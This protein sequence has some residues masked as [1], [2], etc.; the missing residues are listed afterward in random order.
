LRGMS[1]QWSLENIAYRGLKIAGNTDL[2]F[3]Y[4]N[5][6]SAFVVGKFLSMAAFTSLTMNRAVAMKFADRLLYEIQEVMGADISHLSRY[7]EEKELLLIPPCVFLILA[8]RMEKDWLIV[9]LQHFRQ[10]GA[11]Y[12]SVD[13]TNA[14]DA[15][16]DDTNHGSSGNS[17]NSGNNGNSSSGDNNGN[18]SGNSSGNCS[19]NSSG[20]Y[21]GNNRDSGNSS[22]NN[23]NSASHQEG[24]CVNEAELNNYQNQNYF[25]PCE[26]SAG[27]NQTNQ[28]SPGGNDIEY[29]ADDTTEN[30]DEN[31]FYLLDD[32]SEFI[33]ASEKQKVTEF[34][35]V[36][37]IQSK[38]QIANLLH[39]DVE[40]F[41]L[42]Q[43]DATESEIGPTKFQD[44]LK[45]LYL[46][47]KM[48]SSSHVWIV[49]DKNSVNI[50]AT[51]VS[52][53]Q[54]CSRILSSVNVYPSETYHD[55][56]VT[57]AAQC[58]VELFEGRDLFMKAFSS[59][60]G[61]LVST[62]IFNEI[63]IRPLRQL[64]D[65]VYPRSPCTR[66]IVLKISSSSTDDGLIDFLV[67][68]SCFL[69]GWVKLVVV[70]EVV[71]SCAV[72]ASSRFL[73]IDDVG[74]K[75]QQPGAKPE[76]VN[77]PM[78]AEIPLAPQS[79]ADIVRSFYE[80]EGKWTG[81][82][83]S[84]GTYP[85]KSFPQITM[86]PDFGI[87]MSGGGLRA[88]A[89][90][91]GWL[92]ALNKHGLITKARYISVNSGGSWITEPLLWSAVLNGN[93]KVNSSMTVAEVDAVYSAEI[94]ASA[95]YQVPRALTQDFGGEVLDQMGHNFWR[96]HKV[97]V[98]S[99]AVEKLFEEA[100]GPVF[101]KF[102]SYLSVGQQNIE[103]S[104]LPFLIVNGTVVVSREHD[105]KH[106]V[107]V[108]PFEFTPS[109][110]GI[111]IDPNVIAPG[112]FGNNGGFVQNGVFALDYSSTD[113]YVTADATAGIN[114]VHVDRSPTSPTI[115]VSEISSIS[116]SAVVEGYFEQS[117]Y[118]WDGAGQHVL[119]QDFV[120]HKHYWA[121][122]QAKGNYLVG[123]EAK[124][125]DGG[126]TDNTGV[127]ALLRR[128]VGN[129]VALCA[130]N[131][132]IG[133]LRGEHGGDEKYK[134]RILDKLYSY[135]GLFGAV[136]S[137]I[138]SIKEYRAYNDQRKVFQPEQWWE[139]LAIMRNI[140]ANGQPLVH[141]FRSLPVAENPLCGVAAGT[142]NITFVF[143]GV[144]TQYPGVDWKELE[145]YKFENVFE[146]VN[147]GALFGAYPVTYDFPL[148]GVDKLHYS[149]E[150]VEKLSGIAEWSIEEGKVI[151]QL[152]PSIIAAPGI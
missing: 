48:P 146:L 67:K 35:T 77:D 10:K 74:R 84:P 118:D 149:P 46:T 129:I 25:G 127:L 95:A 26:G 139:L 88:A 2:Q 49:D 107:H 52:K 19:W 14:E 99:H 132:D 12:L 45:M 131:T 36:N 111:P 68:N 44:V 124:F 34:F 37:K 138:S 89:L 24:D 11:T 137:E 66:A 61:S 130:L 85:C 128:G 122:N 119:N 114:T 9:T 29:S 94:A 40:S 102:D 51:V 73:I 20:N 92:R 123:G 140:H 136:T 18:T 76:W 22:G 116:S 41:E 69:P 108:A 5:Y 47:M 135:A 6:H 83:W 58:A 42:A 142:V 65:Y 125:A 80:P 15:S 121:Y 98:W 1:K 96:R 21:S 62:D 54:S 17:G 63:V 8:V 93:A 110:C 30:Y 87:A 143:N 27:S 141:T 120:V 72:F 55:L 150:L 126:A 71:P 28:T 23:G 133:P 3:K 50:A 78:P 151:A 97:N 4:D 147:V 81:Q 134:K 70:S 64:T 112:A 106:M 145:E 43:F 103:S 113:K 60:E 59:V 75:I 39:V 100:I 90:G 16:S 115:K 53:L 32:L 57:I 86:K 33:P 144:A 91:L 152:D 105:D 117:I 82:V 109:Y 13:T 7:P 31:S 56:S 148:I 38:P 101:K 104:R 79:Y